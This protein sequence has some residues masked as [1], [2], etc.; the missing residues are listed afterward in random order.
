MTTATNGFT[1]TDGAAYSPNRTDRETPKE[2]SSELDKEFHPTLDAASGETNHKYRK[3]CTAKD[4]AFDHERTGETAFH[5]P[6]DGR[7]IADWAR[8]RSMEASRKNATVVMPIPARTDTRWSHDYIPDR[9]EI[10]SNKGRPRF[11]TDGIPD[12]PAPSPSMIAA[13]R[14]DEE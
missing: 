13:M 4:S 14:S 8:K 6:P 3:Y 9:T 5:N 12:G 7:A 2:P 11:E 1:S 10:R